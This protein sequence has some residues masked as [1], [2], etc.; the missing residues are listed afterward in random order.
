MQIDMFNQMSRVF[1]GSF[2]NKNYMDWNS[3]LAGSSGVLGSIASAFNQRKILKAQQKENELNRQFNHNEAMLARQ[4]N[5]DMFNKTN[6][7]NDPSNVVNRLTKAG[8]NPALAFGGFA[9]AQSISASS[10][11]TMSAG[12]NP[13]SLDTSGISSI[14]NS[15]SAIHNQNKLTDAQVDVLK[16]QAEKNRKDVSWADRLNSSLISLQDSV[17]GLNVA[18]EVNIRKLTP[19]E[20][21]SLSAQINHTLE[22]IKKIKADTRLQSLVADHQFIENQWQHLIK[23]NE[24]MQGVAT[25]KK[26]YASANLDD[27]QAAR[28]G[29]LMAKEGRLLDAQATSIE[30][31]NFV[32]A[33][34][35]A[36]FISDNQR[37]EIEARNQQL[38]AEAEMSDWR[39]D[40]KGWVLALE[41]LGSVTQMILGAAMTYSIAKKPKPQEPR[42]R[43]G[44]R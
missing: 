44:Y 1:N 8:I 18:Q 30:F 15:I 7:Y 20:Q 23:N 3:I 12:V 10:A 33:S 42:P 14:G 34:V 9:N 22:D 17:E 39:S 25:I 2:F 43:V 29:F 6:E 31:D 40:N 11:P 41:S 28:I 16:S 21:E 26:L 38:K 24:F 36:D 5:T 32:N 4:Y 27:K 13:P 37:K 19:Y 35:G